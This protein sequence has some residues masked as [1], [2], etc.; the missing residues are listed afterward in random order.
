VSRIS[1]IERNDD[2]YIQDIIAQ[3]IIYYLS[4]W[5]TDMLAHLDKL[6]EKGIL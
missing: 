4:L 3:K 6:R 1:F 2:M 5:S